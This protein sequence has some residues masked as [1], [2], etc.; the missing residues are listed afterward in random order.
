MDLLEMY[1]LFTNTSGCIAGIYYQGVSQEASECG[2][3]F[4]VPFR[5][6]TVPPTT[7]TAFYPKKKTSIDHPPRNKYL[8]SYGGVKEAPSALMP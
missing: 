5:L 2:L 7:A 1:R 8:R 4:A 3:Y 6:F